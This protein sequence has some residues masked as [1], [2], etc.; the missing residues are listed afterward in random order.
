[1]E[2]GELKNRPV[3]SL[4]DAAR[5]GFIDTALVDLH[6]QQVTGFRVRTGG[7]FTH[8]SA[9]LRED[10]KSLGE[11]A[12]TVED[13]RRLAD[14]GKMPQLKTSVALG[15]L[16]G[17][18]VISEDGKEIGTVADVEMT[19]ET[20]QIESYVLAGGLLDRLRHDKHLLPS[21]SV[22]SIGDKL[23]VVTGQTAVA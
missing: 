6:N 3:V 18:R 17:S 2:F 14:E 5:L 4:A 13:S 20:G 19:V 15:N 7:I 8:H 22:K 11:D 16:L 21:S 12:V 1:M 23:I 10:V 9:I